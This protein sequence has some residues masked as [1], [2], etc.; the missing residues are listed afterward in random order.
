MCLNC[1]TNLFAF[2]SII[3]DDEFI[4]STCNIDNINLDELK[5]MIFVPF[6]LNDEKHA[7]PMYDIDPDVNVFHNYSN[8]FMSSQYYTEDMFNTNVKNYSPLSMSMI[9]L[10]IRSIPKNL[11]NFLNYT[12]N[13]H[14]DFSIYGFT[15]TWLSEDKAKYCNIPNFQHVYKCRESGRGGGV[16]LYVK[17][18]INFNVRDD[19][20]NMSEYCECLFIEI[21]K[22]DV[23]M[24]KNVMCAVIYRP[25]NTNPKDFLTYIENVL[26]QCH[27]ENKICYLMGDYNLNLLKHDSHN[28]TEGFIEV[29]FEHGFFP[30]INKPTRVNSTKATLIDNIFTNNIFNNDKCFNGILVT[31]IS[32]HFPVCYINSKSD[33]SDK[34]NNMSYCRVC[35]PANY[36]S[37]KCAVSDIDWSD[38][39]NNSNAQESFTSFNNTL[40]SLVDKHFPKKAVNHK[41]SSMYKP[42]L[43][44][45]IKKS[46]VVKNKLYNQYILSPSPLRESQ[47][48]LYKNKLTVIIRNA[49]KDYYQNL[50]IVHKSNISM[51]WKIMNNILNRK[52]SKIVNS[53]FLK[54]GKMVTDSN[55]IAEEF[56][57]YFVNVGN[58]LASKIS[59]CNISPLSYINKNVNSSFFIRPVVDSDLYK[60]VKL[61]KKD[62][63]G[64]DDLTGT[65]LKFVVPYISEPLL[66]IVNLS[67]TTGVV[68]RE[69]KIAKVVPIFKSGDASLFCNYRPISLLSIFS[70]VFERLMYFQ[71][72]DY[73]E[74][75]QLLY[76][77]QC[78]FREKYS[79]EIALMSLVDKIIDTFENNRYGVGIFID[80]A[81]AFDTVNHKILL[82]KLHCYGIRG[83]CNDWFHSYLSDRS[84]Y[85]VFNDTLSSHK[86]VNC[87]VPQGSI[88]GPILFILYIN[89]LCNISDKMFF[90]LFAD[91][92]NIYIDGPDLNNLNVIINEEMDKL[93]TW[94]TANKLSLNVKKTNYIVFHNKYKKYIPNSMN[95][96]LNSC[97]I[98]E[99]DKT[100]FLGIIID[101][102]LSWKFHIDHICCKIS[103]SLYLISKARK[104]LASTYLINLYYCFVNSYL[105][106]GIFVWGS[107]VQTTLTKLVLLHKRVI[108]LLSGV[109]KDAHTSPLFKKFN[110]M[111]LADIY[112][113]K[114]AIYVYK[115]CIGVLPN[116]DWLQLKTGAEIHHYNTRNCK[117]F[118]VSCKIRTDYFKG[119]FR[120]TGPNIWGSLS[121]EIKNATSLPSFKK[122]VK[123]YYIESY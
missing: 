50:L 55:I 10:N 18:G 41:K 14:Y 83:I 79:T 32:D 29:M 114:I 64:W 16:S 111:K 30:L 68:P 120:Y 118:R 26:S 104:I 40:L 65:M 37:F 61:I 81:K 96:I 92:T 71:L 107:A 110:L 84:Q 98:S 4:S 76:K 123:S 49:E 122:C 106:Y 103:K 9:H 62:T 22:D 90:L 78:A 113:L 70:K 15:E 20:T 91:D 86:K 115:N 72:I 53:K 93:C 59:S 44:S 89:D 51:S 3:E 42:W 99:V 69:I 87:G 100:K 13:L 58:S 43:T 19:L 77:Y 8:N 56:N 2:N 85:T 97:V 25:P 67:F 88:L 63:P 21:D 66:H 105:Q 80:L 102:K 73:I 31:D 117:N 101:S 116:L 38:V 48:K 109:C 47:Y 1:N 60:A 11:D 12:S 112:K 121:T 17:N 95:V 35:K 57:N 94:F 7:I 34:Q 6:E 33:V 27:N 24:D 36:E 5:R 119:T 108:R 45:A 52:K 75:N 74:K 82:D 54:D 23:N 28:T 46:I 39:L